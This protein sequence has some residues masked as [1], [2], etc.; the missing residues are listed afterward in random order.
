MKYNVDYLGNDV[1]NF[2]ELFYYN[3]CRQ[4]VF[5]EIPTK[6]YQTKT[7]ISL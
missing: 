2:I 7:T 1:N 5:T 4:I 6:N 3:S